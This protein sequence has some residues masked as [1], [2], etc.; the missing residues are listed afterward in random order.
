MTPNR[1]DG[2]RAAALF[3]R[4]QEQ[5]EANLPTVTVLRGAVGLSVQRARGWAEDKGRG[6]VFLSG[7][8]PRL[9]A[10]VDAWADALAGG[11]N[12]VAV[13]TTWLAWRLD[14]P[15]DELGNGL[16][17]KTSLERN[18]F[19]TV[20]LQ[21][22][23]VAAAAC[24][25]LLMQPG[26]DTRGSGLASRLAAALGEASR[27]TVFS[28]L[29]ALLPLDSGPILLLVPP[30]GDDDRRDWVGPA[31]ASLARLAE[32]APRLPLFAAIEP[33]ELDRYHTSA[34]DS[35]AKTL[36]RTGTVDVPAI[37]GPEISRR[38]DAVVPGAS[39]TLAG[40]VKRLVADGASDRLVEL[41]VEA[42]RATAAVTPETEHDEWA[43]SAA[44]RFLFERLD[45]LPLTAGKFAL[46][47]RLDFPFG[48]GQ[49]MEVDLVALELDL[50][51]EIDGY[52]HF[53]NA[54]A[55]R[56][57]RR[58]DLELQKHGFLVVRVL[59]DDVVRRLEEVLDQVLAAVATRRDHPQSARS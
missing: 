58:K 24:R 35:R 7:D 51:L 2:R 12:L 53:R 44:E 54:D 40:P 43:R 16:A 50:A 52:Y 47:R 1:D 10:L 25:W 3:D 11:H 8:D 57:D 13:A 45:T 19:L 38:L 41:F 23:T 22:E 26:A 4:H 17:R 37:D 5:R 42:V 32:I 30:G 15:A 34:P 31:A 59:A 14:C 21:E 29:A 36:F 9:D 55:Y 27:E 20:S 39:T 46:N 49:A 56:R 18:T 48:H 6:A 33:R 28:A